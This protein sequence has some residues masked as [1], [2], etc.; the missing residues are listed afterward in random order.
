MPTAYANPQEAA[1]G[2]TTAF[3][4][5]SAA[6]KSAIANAAALVPTVGGKL[7]SPVS[8][9]PTSTPASAFSTE[10]GA[11]ALAKSQEIAAKLSPPPATLA[12]NS[13][14]GANDAKTAANGQAIAAPAGSTKSG[15]GLWYDQ[16]GNAYSVGPGTTPDNQGGNTTAN[17]AT[18]TL[19]NA[20]TGQEYTL[21]NPSADQIASF[22]SNGWD[23][24]EGTGDGTGIIDTTASPQIKAAQAATDQARNDVATATAQL[25][26]FNVS[27]DPVL[28]GQLASITQNWNSR[29]A[30]MEQSNKGQVANTTTL[31]IRL[32]DR[33]TGGS[34]GMFGGII[35]AEES[36]G[37]SRIN[38]LEAQKQQ[39]LSAASK[40][41]S[42]QQW[43]RYSKLVD[44]AETAYHDQ[45]DQLNKL[46]TAAATATKNAQDA[47]TKQQEDYY[48]QVTKPIN[49]MASDVLKSTGDAKLAQAI[50]S[51]PDLA[52]AVATAGDSLQ[53]GSGIVGEYLFY[54]RQAQAQGQMPVDF[55][56]YQTIDANRKAK[57]TAGAGSTTG[58]V[59]LT[60]FDPAVRS[61]LSGNG[62]TKF[63]GG[64]Q[65]LA[66]QLV[67]GQIAPSE[68][69]KR[70]TGTASYND[71]LSAANLYSKATTNQ[72]FNIAQA[73]RDYKFATRPQTQDTLNYLGSLVGSDDGTGNVSGGNLDELVTLSNNIGRTTFPAV[74]NIAA[75]TRYSV[76][77]PNIAAFQ[78]TATEVADQVAKILQGGGSS[79]TSDAKLQ[80]AAN[81]FNTSFTKAQMLATVAALKPLLAN[82]A[83]SMIKDNAYLSD[84]ADQFGI[85]QKVPGVPL[86]T[87]QTI[88]QQNATDP[89]QLG[90]APGSTSSSNPLGI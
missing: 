69:S 87:S 24:A 78:A 71:V 64:V 47:V 65:D 18:V 61:K 28:A 40:A 73:D 15:N 75:W 42:D 45:V 83:K 53:T 32:G 12:G 11:A 88:I 85:K 17:K 35:S 10:A 68:L 46:Q 6:Q 13:Y 54:K 79:G 81:L 3:S 58:S 2:L 21:N 7:P 16:G 23:I 50:A 89:L 84:Y 39:A 29:I 41:Y 80:Q 63:P 33:Y 1:A 8:T 90:P 26:N 70:T 82:R 52:T 19:V 55:N 44:I 66:S 14:N 38:D 76:G 37:V 56:T 20:A 30:Q 22:K 51:S 77:D 67:N 27:N 74:N 9:T 86:S 72:P 62:F 36:A 31:G 57:A 48:N 60:A 34:G 43:D 5:T 25:T 49:D 4:P 59:D